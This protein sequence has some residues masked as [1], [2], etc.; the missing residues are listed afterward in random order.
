LSQPR[1]HGGGVTEHQGRLQRRRR[2]AGM[3][4]EQSLRAARCAA[5]GAPDEFVNRSI[6]RKRARFDFVTQ[7]FPGRET[8][9]TGDNRLGVV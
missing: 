4:F 7:C 9:L 6:E 8:V 3:D 1:L 5:R 2:N